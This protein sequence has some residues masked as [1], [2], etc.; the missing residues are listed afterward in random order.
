MQRGQKCCKRLHTAMVIYII[1]L[2]LIG[3]SS[4]GHL[5]LVG[6][7][8]FNACIFLFLSRGILWFIDGEE[9]YCIV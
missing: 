1:C 2:S 4:F 3:E 5:D 6:S 8:H 9:F 7:I